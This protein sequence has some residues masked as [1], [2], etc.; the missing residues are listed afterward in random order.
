MVGAAD[1]A[2]AVLGFDRFSEFGTIHLWLRGC[3]VSGECVV[4][5]A[6]GMREGL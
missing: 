6:V 5:G 1:G 4:P 2:V 3:S